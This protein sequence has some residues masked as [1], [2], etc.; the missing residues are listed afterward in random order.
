M[1]KASDLGLGTLVMGIRDEKKIRL[2]LEIPAN[3]TVI[4]VIGL[5][6]GQTRMERPVRK[7][8]EQ[9]TKTY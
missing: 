4:S 6:Y 2:L 8:F 5:G 3:E 7:S 1:L 9:L